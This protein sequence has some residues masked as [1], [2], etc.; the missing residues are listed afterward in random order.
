[1]RSTGCRSSGAVAS[2]RWNP[3]RRNACP[4]TRAEGYRRGGGRRLCCSNPPIYIG[5]DGLV[6]GGAIDSRTGPSL[7]QPPAIQLVAAVDSEF[8]PHYEFAPSLV[9]A[10]PEPID[11]S[12]PSGSLWKVHAPRV[13]NELL[14]A[15]VSSINWR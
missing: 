4:H 6:V 5:A 13:R 8:A 12:P 11:T 2:P 15:N 1:M 7:L 9:A 10:C 14:V 3:Q